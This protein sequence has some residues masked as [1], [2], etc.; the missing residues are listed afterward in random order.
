[1]APSSPPV[2]YSPNESGGSFLKQ[3]TQ[4]IKHLL[5]EQL[6][7]PARGAYLTEQAIRK[8]IENEVPRL[9]TSEEKARRDLVKKL[10]PI[11][12]HEATR[13][14]YSFDQVLQ[15]L[16]LESAE[17]RRLVDEGEIRAFRDGDAIKF[18][19]SDIEGLKKGL[20][21]EPTII[22]PSGEEGEVLLVE[23]DMSEALLDLDEIEV[24]KGKVLPTGDFGAAP[25][26]TTTA[27]APEP[28]VSKA[29]PQRKAEEK[30]VPTGRVS[31]LE[32]PTKEAQK[33]EFKEEAAGQRVREEKQ[34]VVA[35]KKIGL[36]PCYLRE[37]LR[38]AVEMLREKAAQKGIPV[39]E[40]IL[41]E[42]AGR[43]GPLE[44]ICAQSVLFLRGVEATIGLKFILLVHACDITLEIITSYVH[45]IFYTWKRMKSVQKRL[46]QARK[47]NQIPALVEELVGLRLQLSGIFAFV[48]FS[49]QENWRKLPPAW[50]EKRPELKHPTFLLRLVLETRNHLDEMKR[51]LDILTRQEI[52]KLLQKTFKDWLGSL[53]PNPLTLLTAWKDWFILA[54]F[55]RY[56]RAEIEKMYLQVMADYRLIVFLLERE[57]GQKLPQDLEDWRAYP[58]YEKAMQS[59]LDRIGMPINIAGTQ[60]SAWVE[61]TKADLQRLLQVLT[62]PGRFI[63]PSQWPLADLLWESKNTEAISA[64]ESVYTLE[65]ER[66][67]TA[68]VERVFRNKHVHADAAEKS[69]RYQEALEL[70]RCYQILQYLRRQF[71]F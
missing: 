35:G 61:K 3:E 59:R 42:N 41:S 71:L 11:P 50:Q 43:P 37:L 45:Q 28:P 2:Y 33:P 5:F 36:K 23:E 10:P 63:Y 20:L 40:F 32:P 14:Y 13:E 21:T 34:A 24:E 49:L 65:C 8:F 58:D 46:E 29:E 4:R 27:K 52:I 64:P 15:A 6:D 26:P 53:I 25:A 69:L 7:G 56:S 55:M 60:L 68:E 47:H 16:Q 9:L 51:D 48:R 17:L 38:K 19:K 22:L 54:F 39:F 66:R 57:S 18:K 44:R 12:R 31:T 70:R 30:P 67:L 62:N 1:M